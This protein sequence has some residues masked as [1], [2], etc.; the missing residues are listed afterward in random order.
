MAAKKKPTKAAAEA[1]QKT[2]EGPEA[3]Q[4]EQMPAEAQAAADTPV[5]IIVEADALAQE[6]VVNKRVK[7]Y[8]RE[9]PSKDALVIAILPGG[10]GV[11]PD[12]PREGDPEWVH[13]RTGL[14]SGWVMAQFLE[15][16]PAPEI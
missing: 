6:C 10:V 4:A 14:L 1:V 11:F 3:I 8:L 13:V 12:G 16:L 7:I 9:K 15:A 2:Q 5:E